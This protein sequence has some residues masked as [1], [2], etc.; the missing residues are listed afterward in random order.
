MA[1][2]ARFKIMDAFDDAMLSLA[3][4]DAYP[5]VVYEDSR[6]ATKTERFMRRA[7]IPECTGREAEVHF[8]PEGWEPDFVFPPGGQFPDNLMNPPE[9][10]LDYWRSEWFWGV[11]HGGNWAFDLPTLEFD[12]M[13][14]YYDRDSKEDRAFVAKLWRLF[15]R[16]MTNRL[17]HPYS[18]RPFMQ[19]EAKGGDMWAGHHVLEWCL[20]GKRRMLM[21]HSV[22][23]DDWAP[24][25]SDWHKD[26]RRRVVEKFGPG[27]GDPTAG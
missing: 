27:I 21:G 6:A 7:S 9:Y 26:L 19:A 23:C 17:K 3:L 1:P 10:N 8:V 4:E 25:D 5:N 24:P 14:M 22:P 18:P 13:Y 20:G 2:R 12:Q 16:L 11:P 15:G